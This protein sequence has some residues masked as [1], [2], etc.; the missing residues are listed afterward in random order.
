MK[1]ILITGPS[2]SGKTFLSNKISD[3]YHGTI[4]IKTDSFYRDN[5]II[6]LLALFLYDIY[7]RLISIKGKDIVNTIYSIQNKDKFISL[8]DYDFRKRKSTHVIKEIK[9]QK[10]CRYLILEGIFAHR[11][12]LNYKETINVICQDKKENCYQRRSRRDQLERG[13]GREEVKKKFTKSWDLYYKNSK[14]FRRNNEVI[15]T[16]P[17]DLQS[18]NKLIN[19][20]E[21]ISIYEKT[22]ENI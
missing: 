1:L 7:D 13:R 8:Y 19:R 18:Y 22:K 16:T 21:E 4:V 5:I 20:I 11:L 3:F 15:N 12:N 17:V 14:Q 10:D 9:Y 6:K 2:G